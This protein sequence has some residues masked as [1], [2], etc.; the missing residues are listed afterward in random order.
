[1]KVVGAGVYFLYDGNEL[2]YIG[3]SFCL[4]CIATHKM[5]IGRRMNIENG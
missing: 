2:V 5:E 4:V 1:M 3:T